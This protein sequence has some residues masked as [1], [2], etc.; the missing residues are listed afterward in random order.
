MKFNFL[1]VCFF[2]AFNQM[3]AQTSKENQFSNSVET[4]S[5]SDITFAEAETLDSY[6]F[7]CTFKKKYLEDIRK[8]ITEEYPSFNENIYSKNDSFELKIEIKKCELKLEF[9][10][11]KGQVSKDKDKLKSISSKIKGLTSS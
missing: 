7:S 5:N 6:A 2:L 1:L 11:L 3:T 4:N 9:K 8:F 10:S